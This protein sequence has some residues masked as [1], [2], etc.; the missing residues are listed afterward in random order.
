MNMESSIAIRKE[1][2]QNL[3]RFY[4]KDGET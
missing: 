4:K 3:Q 1:Y 2:K